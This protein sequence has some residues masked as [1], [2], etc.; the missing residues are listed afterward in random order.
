M[1]DILIAARAK[2]ASPDTWTQH[3]LARDTNDNSHPD[4]HSYAKYIHWEGLNG[5]DPQACK[6]CA[7][8]AVQAVTT[9][10]NTEFYRVRN[11]L[12]KAAK[13]LFGTHNIAEVNDGD[14]GHAAVLQC[15]DHAINTI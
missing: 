5:R 3:V 8:G 14:H 4:S 7:V 2:I 15:Y 11:A 12:D 10:D 13:Q 6:F 1:K 9:D